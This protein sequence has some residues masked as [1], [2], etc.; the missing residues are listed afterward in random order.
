VVERGFARAEEEPATI[1]WF[2][3]R[4]GLSEF[5]IFD[6]LA[7]RRRPPSP[8]W[9]QVAAALMAQAPDLLGQPPAI[10]PVDILAAKL[11][12]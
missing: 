6:S 4:L 3:I 1:A 5:G 12:S 10:E 7:R 9:G 11:P 8:P 2:A